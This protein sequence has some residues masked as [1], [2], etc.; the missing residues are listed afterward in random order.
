[1]AVTFVD[2]LTDDSG[3]A[4]NPDELLLAAPCIDSV[5]GHLRAA[6]HITPATSGDLKAECLAGESYGPY[7]GDGEEVD[8][9]EPTTMALLALGLAGLGFGRRRQR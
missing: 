7:Y 6:V 4:S 1:M 3:S 8:V 9:P 5:P 2:A